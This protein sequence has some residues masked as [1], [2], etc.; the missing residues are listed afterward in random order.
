MQETISL[1]AEQKINNETAKI[2]VSIAGATGYVGQELLRLLLQHPQVEIASLGSSSHDGQSFA[3]LCPQMR[4]Q[5]EKVLAPTNL[6]ELSQDCDVLF[7]ALPHGT[8]GA[9]LTKKIV[10]STKI[11]D[12][13]GD[14]RLL[15][16]AEIE[17]WYGKAPADKSL[18]GE[19]VYGLPELNK[20]KISASS[21][22]ANPGCYATAAILAL[23][24]LAMA[25]LIV[26]NSI[27]LDGK[28]GV[29]GAGRLLSQSLQFSE[30]NESIKAYALPHHK[31]CAEIEQTLGQ[32]GGAQFITTFAAHLVPM[33]RG[34]L[35]TSYAQLK[36][37]STS[38]AD[39]DDAFHSLYENEPFIRVSNIGNGAGMPETRWVK[40]TNFCDIGYTIDARTNKI[41]IVSAI[42][43]LVKGAAGQAIQNM[44]LMFGHPE[45]EG[46]Q[47]VSYFPG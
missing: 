23:A 28:S 9:T 27:V 25:G 17:K 6:L 38:L 5:C 26:E 30:C 46:L 10:D 42:D 24:P 1:P 15:S 31:H 19:A 33:N 40:G 13:S 37:E 43:N 8:S 36:S 41:V 7:L 35:M 18:V 11:I 45:T 34:I 20:K 39:V 29:S 44:N 4:K 3:E 47:Q 32:V 16:D 14:F 21:F 12:L 2:R 22:I